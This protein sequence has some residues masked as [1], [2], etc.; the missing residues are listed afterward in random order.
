[1]DLEMAGS[2]ETII[3]ASVTYSGFETSKILSVAK[4]VGVENPY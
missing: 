2:S 3:A 1:M 4:Y